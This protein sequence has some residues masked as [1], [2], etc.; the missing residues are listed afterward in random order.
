MRSHSF[1]RQLLP[2]SCPGRLFALSR[3]PSRAWR[4]EVEHRP[5]IRIPVRRC[6]AASAGLFRRVTS[7]FRV[8][9]LRSRSSDLVA[10]KAGIWYRILPKKALSWP[11]GTPRSRRFPYLCPSSSRVIPRGILAKLDR[12]GRALF[13][14]R[15]ADPGGHEQLPTTVVK[16][17]RPRVVRSPSG[18]S[19]RSASRASLR[20]KRSQT[21]GLRR[22]PFARRKR[23]TA[24][25]RLPQ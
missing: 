10:N 12:P 1:D 16:G 6:C 19:S 9:F 23:P 20:C 13:D 8:R 21:A 4:S 2:Q 3:S 17:D 18:S 5:W 24:R 22:K 15:T 25:T 11:V 7:Q 14:T